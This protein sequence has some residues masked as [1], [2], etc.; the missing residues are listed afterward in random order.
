LLLREKVMRAPLI[1][2]D[3]DTRWPRFYDEE[4]T[5]ILRVIGPM[6]MGIEH[7]GSTAVPGLAAEPIID[8]MIG[9][10]HLDD[11][12]W[13]I[14]PLKTLGYEYVPELGRRDPEQRYFRKGNKPGTEQGAT[15]H[16]YVTE[17][18]SD[19][20]DRLLLFRDYLRAHPDEAQRYVELKKTLA[21]RSGSD[22]ERYYSAKKDF[23]GEIVDKERAD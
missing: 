10:R 21:A 4:K 11:A 18:G 19:F 3:Y 1:I 9:T 20:W 16:L 15:H 5:N 23:V 8:I 6:V 12:T 13:C 22:R 14:Q 2:V 17:L 7:V